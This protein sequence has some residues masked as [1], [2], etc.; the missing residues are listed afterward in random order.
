MNC[1]ICRKEAKSHIYYCAKCAVYI[2]EKCWLRH[3]TQEHK[4]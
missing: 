4:K 2:H 1:P 3:M